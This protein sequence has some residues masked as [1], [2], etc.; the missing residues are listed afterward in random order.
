MQTFHRAEFL[1]ILEKHIPSNYHTHFS[2]RLTSYEDR[3][4]AS[5]D[6]TSTNPIVLHFTDGTIAE[7]D[8]LVGADGVKSAVRRSMFTSLALNAQDESQAAA[9]RGCVEATWSG[10]VAYRA[11]VQASTF[12]VEYPEHP[13]ISSPVCVSAPFSF[14]ISTS[15]TMLI[16]NE[17]LNFQFMGKYA[18]STMSE[19]NLTIL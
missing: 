15:A 5:L 13:V 17:R 18:V 14:S 9:Y 4:Q 7:C 1:K 11:L 16:P 10:I 12:S 2:K 8:V 6:S 3:S 19:R